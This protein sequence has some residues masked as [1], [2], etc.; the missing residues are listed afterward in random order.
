MDSRL[1]PFTIQ[2][3]HSVE[4]I[5]KYSRLPEN[6]VAKA[7]LR[8][9]RE[10]ERNNKAETLKSHIGY[11][12]I[13]DGLPV[14]EKLLK[15]RRSVSGL[16]KKV[17]SAYAPVVYVLGALCLTALIT[18]LLISQARHEDLQDGILVLIS[19][20]S[21]LAA[22]HFA[23]AITNWIATLRVGP[24]PL[25]KMDFSQGIS[26]ESRTLVVVPALLTSF[27]S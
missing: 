25:P 16:F 9:A 24:K 8:L 22:S 27:S 6:D 15:T 20:L 3:R 12:L 18:F 2:Y 11:Y 10:S 17:F 26:R 23:I 1:E 4:K 13:G 21:A 19:F 14:V 7:V 5:A